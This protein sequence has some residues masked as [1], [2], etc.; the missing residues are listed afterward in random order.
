MKRKV[1][2]TVKRISK[3]ENEEHGEEIREENGE[4]IS[5]ERK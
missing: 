2:S 1:R 4:D 3:I 5:G